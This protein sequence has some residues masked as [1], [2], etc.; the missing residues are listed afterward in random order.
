MAKETNQVLGHGAEADGIEE[1]DNPLPDWWLGLFIFCIIY[2]VGYAINYHFIA[3][4]SQELRYVAMMEEAEKKWPAQEGPVAVV[5]DDASIQAG[6]DV[7]NQTCA[8]CHNADLTGGIGP[9]LTDAEWIHGGEP[10]NVVNTITNGV[11]AKGMPAWGPILGPKKVQQVAAFVL[12]KKGSAP[13][14]AQAGTAA[15][16]SD[17]PEGGQDGVA[18]AEGQ[19]EKLDGKAIYDQNCASCHAPDMTGLVGPSLVDDEW[20][21]GGELAQITATI[22]NGVPEKGMIQW[23][24]VLGEEKIAVVAQFVHSKGQPD[25]ANP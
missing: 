12:S 23:G 16:P 21:H 10:A 6:A 22:T 4:D 24:P 2:G 5:M 19:P 1:Y 8:S 17:T 15:G 11:A 3:N 9:N 7:Y 20:I 13:A 18:A 25:Q 14:A